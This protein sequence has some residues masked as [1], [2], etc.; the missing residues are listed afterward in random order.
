MW[1]T[2]QKTYREPILPGMV[3]DATT[4]G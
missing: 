4:V 1:I 2:G 3:M